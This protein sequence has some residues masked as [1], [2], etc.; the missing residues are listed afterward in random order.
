MAIAREMSVATKDTSSEFRSAPLRSARPS[1]SLNAD[2]SN[3]WGSIAVG[4][5]KSGA[6]ARVNIHSNGASVNTIMNSSPTTD[7]T[8]TRRGESE[9]ITPTAPVTIRTIANESQS[10]RSGP[11]TR[12]MP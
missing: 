10:Q 4:V 3:R 1:A 2:H 7:Q 8:E 5:P 11:S 9:M 6:A 12:R